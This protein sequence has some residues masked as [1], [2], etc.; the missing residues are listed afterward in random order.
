MVASAAT[1]FARM[2]P[3]TERQQQYVRIAAAAANQGEIPADLLL[4]LETMLDVLLQPERAVREAGPGAEQV[5]LGVYR[6]TPRGASLSA[7]AREV[8]QALRV[9]RGQSLVSLGVE[10]RPGRH[11]LTLE[12]DRCRVVLR[13][14]SA[15]ARVESLEVG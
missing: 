12:T 10:S 14:D 1:A 2:L 3:H 4:A 5:L 7:A 11:T 9:L 8:N 15:G 13:L 6:R